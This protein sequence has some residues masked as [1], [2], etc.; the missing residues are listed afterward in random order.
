MKKQMIGFVLAT[1]STLALAGAA[2]DVPVEIDMDSKVAFGNMK[3]ARFSSNEFEQI[4]CGTRTFGANDVDPGFSWG[5]CQAQIIEGES[6]ICFAY[7]KPDLID[8]IKALDSFSFVTFRWDDEGNCTYVGSST[9]SQYIP[10]KKFK[11]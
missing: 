8:Q 4:G 3:T 5:F 6:V 1:F 2:I 10:S 7:D 9:Q 11:D